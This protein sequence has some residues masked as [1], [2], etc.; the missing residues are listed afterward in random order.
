MRTKNPNQTQIP[1]TATRVSQA[2]KKK[3]QFL[4]PNRYNV[5]PVKMANPTL[6]LCC[7]SSGRVSVNHVI[8]EQSNKSKMDESNGDDNPKQKWKKKAP[9]TCNTIRQIRLPQ[10]I[11]TK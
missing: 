11:G 3:P 4:F 10:Y 6:Y 9:E 8:R 5:S 1:D 7:S 2:K